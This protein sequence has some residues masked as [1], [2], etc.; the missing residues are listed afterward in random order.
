LGLIK[1][2]NYRLFYHTL[3]NA[4]NDVLS[5][6]ILDME[7]E[8]IKQPQDRARNITRGVGS[9][10]L[11]NALTS[12]LGFVFLAVCVRFTSVPDF[13]AYSAILVSITVGIT[14]STFSLQY[15]ASRYLALPES[16]ESDIWAAGRSILILSIIFTALATAVF[17]ALAPLLSQY[18]MKSSNWTFLFQLGGLWLLTYSISTVMQGLIAGIKRYTTLA[19]MMSISRIIM[20]I[21]TIFE[22]DSTHSISFAIIAWIINYV[23]IIAWSLYLIGPN[24]MKSRQLCRFS[25][26]LRYSTPLAIASILGILSANADLIIVGGYSQTLGVYNTAVQI[27][28]VLS[29]ILTTPLTT[30]L[31][32]EA[33]SSLN[34][35]KEITNGIRLSFRFLILILLPTSFIMAAESSQLL[36]LFSGGGVYLEGV[37]P[38]QII[39]ITYIFFAIHFPIYS[40][41]QAIG[42]TVQLL[43]T[44][45]VVAVVDVALAFLLVPS[46]GIIGGSID[47]AIVGLVWM[48][49]TMYFAKS[50]LQHLDSYQFYV[51]ATASS[52][53]SFVVVLGLTIMSDRTLTLIP[54]ALVGGVIFLLCVKFTKILTDEDRALFSH[55]LPRR[56][57]VIL[58]FL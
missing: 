16:S 27:S 4:E 52:L 32:P 26:L 36:S 56:L 50:Y 57:Q 49:S 30:A 48:V 9:L 25:E 41:L 33:S 2:L 15:A 29:L 21:F 55:L 20:L 47:R 10:A 54:Y 51:K 43:I 14:I 19:M 31:L 24:L 34:N 3:N 42:R 38:L 17:V 35:D 23:I 37:F 18:Y 12:A 11:Q 28:S 40:A 58:R 44:G 45:A 6:S 8:P 7:D 5:H 46:F 13:T 39:T 22:L 1:E 53:V